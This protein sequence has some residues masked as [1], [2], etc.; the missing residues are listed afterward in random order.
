MSYVNQMSNNSARA[1]TRQLRTR[2]ARH[3]YCL[4][5]LN[6]TSTQIYMLVL[7][8][9]D[10]SIYRILQNIASLFGG[11]LLPA[12]ER[13]PELLSVLS[14]GKWKTFLNNAVIYHHSKPNTSLLVKGSRLRPKGK[15]SRSTLRA[16]KIR[17]MYWSESMA[18]T[19]LSKY[20]TSR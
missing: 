10:T 17:S 14:F 5:D 11:C 1:L 18:S 4:A 7:I 13:Y 9:Y 15:I 16:P 20:I 3:F 8:I 2:Y 12:V 19:S 6:M